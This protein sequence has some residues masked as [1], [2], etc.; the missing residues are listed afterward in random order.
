MVVDVITVFGLLIG[1]KKALNINYW[2]V[3]V[4]FFK[5]FLVEIKCSAILFFFFFFAS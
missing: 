1:T 3:I 5:H 2:I 4:I